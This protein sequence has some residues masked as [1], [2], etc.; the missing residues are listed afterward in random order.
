MFADRFKRC[1]SR[2]T[3]VRT[4]SDEL[5]DSDDSSGFFS[6]DS[7]Q[8]MN[9]NYLM[10]NHNM[11]EEE[12]PVMDDEAKG[13]MLELAAAMRERR[14]DKLVRHITKHMAKASVPQARVDAISKALHEAITSTMDEVQQSQAEIMKRDP[15][16]E[17][18]EMDYLIQ[19]FTDLVGK[20]EQL[21]Q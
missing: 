7:D 16:V 2:L 4:V 20:I 8:T 14:A 6:E 18:S 5:S 19:V 15:S 9:S 12:R 3:D 17:F 11:P 21:L 13:R 10:M 1:W